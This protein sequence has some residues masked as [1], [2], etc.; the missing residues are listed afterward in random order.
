MNKYKFGC[1]YKL[2]SKETDKFYIGSTILGYERLSKHKSSYKNSIKNETERKTDCAR[3]SYFMLKYEDCD[4]ELI[5]NFPC[6]NEFEL[7][8][9]ERE[10]IIKLGN[11][12]NQQ[13]PY[14]KKYIVKKDNKVSINQKEYIKDFNKEQRKDPE[15]KKEENKRKR[16]AR[17][18]EKGK[19]EVK[20][21]NEK[22]SWKRWYKNYGKDLKWFNDLSKNSLQIFPPTKDEIRNKKRRYKKIWYLNKK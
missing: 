4:M 16:I 3:A 19:A 7:R 17:Q 1:I 15:Y 10:L 6:N 8:S 21:G 22:A 14:D 5:E 12:L 9:R 18:G 20:R 13:L 11:P 2:V